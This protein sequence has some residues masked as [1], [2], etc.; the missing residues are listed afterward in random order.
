[1]SFIKKIIEFLPAIVNKTFNT[2]TFWF[3]H[4]EVGDAWDIRGRL[5][6]RNHGNLHIGNG[7]TVN[8]NF[9]SNP[10]GGPYPSALDVNEGATL[11]IGNNVGMSGT[12]VMCNRSITIEDDVRFGSGCCIYDTDFHSLSY[13]KRIKKIDNDIKEKPVTIKKGVFVG[14]RTI[15]LKGVVIGEYSVVGA[16]SVVT[17]DIPS[18][19]IWAGNPAQFV[20]KLVE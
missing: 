19:E 18:N 10:V 20:R 15:I 2:F 5:F 1:M 8:C 17:R 4:V 3:W 9:R 16:G 7:F 13:E 11:T 12:V 14:A 6:I